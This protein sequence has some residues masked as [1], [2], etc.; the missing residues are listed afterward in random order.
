MVSD[1]KKL[2]RRST[3]HVEQYRTWLKSPKTHNLSTPPP[4]KSPRRPCEFRKSMVRIVLRGLKNSWVIRQRIGKWD[5]AIFWHQYPFCTCSA[6]SNQV[7][8][9]I[10]D[11]TKKR[12]KKLLESVIIAMSM[13]SSKL[14]HWRLIKKY[15]GLI[16]QN[17]G[18]FMEMAENAIEDKVF[19]ILRGR[20]N[21]KWLCGYL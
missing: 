7:S 14:N 13:S 9:S 20:F 6:H 2:C 8:V 19:K 10:Q 21:Q 5:L 18:C 12:K 16:N 4:K 17:L 1:L 3:R 11:K 15:Y